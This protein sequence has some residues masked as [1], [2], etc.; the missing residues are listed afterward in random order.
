[1]EDEESEEIID[2]DKNEEIFNEDKVDIMG[3]FQT[4]RFKNESDKSMGLEVLVNDNFYNLFTHFQEENSILIS[5]NR[6][7]K[8]SSIKNSNN[9]RVLG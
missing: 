7:F 8:T 9:D 1:D 5:D 4:I 3:T 2:N 6:K